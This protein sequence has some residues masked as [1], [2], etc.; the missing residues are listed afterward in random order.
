ML[1]Q[2]CFS[3]FLRF[4]VRTQNRENLYKHWTPCIQ[5]MVGAGLDV[6]IFQY[7]TFFFFIFNLSF[8]RVHNQNT[9]FSFVLANRAFTLL[10]SERKKMEGFFQIHSTEKPSY[11]LKSINLCALTI[12]P[13]VCIFPEQKSLENGSEKAQAQ[14]VLHTS[15]KD[16]AHDR[17]CEK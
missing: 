2:L 5:C 4:N 8:Y 1:M 9:Q 17:Q 7:K 6:Q 13:L 14:D 12:Y 11:Q 16:K 15:G 10:R 3:I